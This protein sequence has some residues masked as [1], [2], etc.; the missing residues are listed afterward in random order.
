MSEDARD[1][2]LAAHARWYEALNAMLA[3]DPE[4]F[5]E[6]YSHS[7]DVSYMPA[8]GGLLVG[9]DAAFAKVFRAAPQPAFEAWAVKE[10]R[11]APKSR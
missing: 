3:G 6:I 9:F 5:A 10:A 4:P 7:D 2:V 1:A 8:E 11:R